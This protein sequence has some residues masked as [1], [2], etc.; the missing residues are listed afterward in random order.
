MG[1]IARPSAWFTLSEDWHCEN[2]GYSLYQ[3]ERAF[4]DVQTDSVVCG[5]TCRDYLPPRKESASERQVK[6]S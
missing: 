1:Y 4:Y 3:G 2:C 6:R 5:K